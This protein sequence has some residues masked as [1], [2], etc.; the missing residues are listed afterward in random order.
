M[1]LNQT[2]TKLRIRA[3]TLFGTVP[4]ITTNPSITLLYEFYHFYWGE[5]ISEQNNEIL[6]MV[7]AKYREYVIKSARELYKIDIETFMFKYHEWNINKYPEEY[8][9]D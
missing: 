2:I 1:D 3:V 7:C 5:S 9:D 6:Q 8:V 4:E